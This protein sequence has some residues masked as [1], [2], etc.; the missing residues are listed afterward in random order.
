MSSHCVHSKHH[1]QLKPSVYGH[2]CPTGH[3]RPSKTSGVFVPT[4]AAGGYSADCGQ[5]GTPSAW[6]GGEG[7]VTE[8]VEPISCLLMGLKSQVDILVLQLCC[9][10]QNAKSRGLCVA[11]QNLNCVCPGRLLR[12]GCLQVHSRG[13]GTTR[14]CRVLRLLSP[15]RCHGLPNKPCI[16]FLFI[17]N[18]IYLLNKCYKR[19]MTEEPERKSPEVSNSR[20][21][22]P[23]HFNF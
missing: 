3:G 12:A 20:P 17:S 16:V 13:V 10:C 6:D 21:H 23:L 18:T 19:P 2:L 11:P 5:E 22:Q 9:G 8:K 1:G 4:S 15:T 7:V 14:A